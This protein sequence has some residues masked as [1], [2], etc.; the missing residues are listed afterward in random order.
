MAMLRIV[1]GVLATLVC[2]AMCIRG[3][4]FPL[5][6]DWRECCQDNDARRRAIESMRDECWRA[7][8]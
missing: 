3:G 7:G 5:R 2:K 6:K 1:S 8:L 4:L